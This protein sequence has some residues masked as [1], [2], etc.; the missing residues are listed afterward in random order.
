MKY[1][2]FALFILLSTSA[3]AHQDPLPP[4]SGVVIHLFTPTPGSSTP[5]S[6]GV[7]LK[8]MF[9]TGDPSRTPGDALS[10]GKAST[11]VKG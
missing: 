3:Q 1:L 4:P 2:F 9:V 5:P 8:Q 7:I 10:K 11:P 6:T